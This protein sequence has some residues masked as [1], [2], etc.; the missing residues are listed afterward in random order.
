KPQGHV[1]AG[2][3]GEPSDVN[4]FTTY[5]PLGRRLVLA[6]THDSLL[7]L[8]PATGALRPALAESFEVS[9][10]GTTC[11]FTLRDSVVFSDGSPMTMADA[12]FGWELAKAGHLSLGFVGQG[13]ERVASVESMD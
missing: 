5:D 7:D 2:A 4:P 6:Y 3:A 11:T 10:D 9:A 1:Y 13:F 8:D 12:M